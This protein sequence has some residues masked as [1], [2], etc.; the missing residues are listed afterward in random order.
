MKTR[1]TT[2]GKTYS[3]HT[4]KGCTIIEPDGWSK[5][6]EA[7]DGY[8]DA[9]FG[10]VVIEGDDEASIKQLFKLA[11]QQRLA[12]LGV[13]GG[14][15]GGLP[16]GYKRVEYLESTRKQWIDTLYYPCWDSVIDTE[17]CFLNS[18]KN[19]VLY[20][21]VENKTEGGWD[22]AYFVCS[23]SYENRGWVSHGKQS[24][25]VEITG[26]FKFGIKQVFNTSKDGIFI[27]GLKIDNAIEPSVY[28]NVHS[29]YLFARN[30]KGVAELPTESRIWSF[31]VSE[32]G[33][34]KRDF[35]P[36]L[37]PTGAPCM[38]DLVSRKPYYNRGAGD[39]LYPTASTTYSLRR[40]LPDWGKLTEH[41][42]RRLYHAPANYKG[43]LYDYA[44]EH[45]Y[46]PIV[47]PEKPEEGYWTP[48]WT[49]TE[50]EI[51]LEW[52]ETEPPADEFGLPAEELTETE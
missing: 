25:I 23:Y 45:G 39:F 50:D 27:D 22:G 11:P 47:E 19:Y 48:R 49:E 26:L 2:P 24:G 5:T 12:I 33:V 44:L 42:L 38:F 10:S 4:M 30:Y 35:V 8:F 20:A 15:T 52:V 46:K 43:E 40:V 21:T 17:G 36:C 28:R 14:N 1:E 18:N 32:K 16:A 29:L 3:V 7:P 51:V 41:G 13:L 6:I 9:H 31:K 37:D 34:T